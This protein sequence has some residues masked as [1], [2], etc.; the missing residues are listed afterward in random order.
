MEDVASNST[1]FSRE[2]DDKQL[3]ME[4]WGTRFLEQPKWSYDMI[5]VCQEWGK[6]HM[7]ILNCHGQR[8]E[9]MQTSRLDVLTR[10]SNSFGLD[11]AVLRTFLH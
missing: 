6:V 2:R 10:S 9:E 5:C 3:A 4:L 8:E 7:D 11:V 1:N